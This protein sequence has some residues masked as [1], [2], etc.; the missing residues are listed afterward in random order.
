[1]RRSRHA[2]THTWPEKAPFGTNQVR[3]SGSEGLKGLNSG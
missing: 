1:M 2:R 3:K